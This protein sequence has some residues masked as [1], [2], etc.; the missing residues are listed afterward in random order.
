MAD[1]CLVGCVEDYDCKKGIKKPVEGHN[2]APFVRLT[3]AGSDGVGIS[4]GNESDPSDNNYAVIKSFQFG[5]SSGAGCVLEIHDQAGGS[6][7]R[8]MKKLNRC[9]KNA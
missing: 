7:E 1:N 4:V 8:V 2:L 6:F 3:I 9:I 5:T